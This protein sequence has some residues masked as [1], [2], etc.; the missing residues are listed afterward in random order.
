MRSHSLD[1]PGE[2]MHIDIL[3]NKQH[4][5]N[6]NLAFTPWKAVLQPLSRLRPHPVAPRRGARRQSDLN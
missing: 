1:T 5:T 2:G 6:R 3:D 4:N